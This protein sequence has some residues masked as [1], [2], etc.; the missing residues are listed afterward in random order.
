M[1]LGDF[2][3]G[4]ITKSYTREIL[5]NQMQEFSNCIQKNFYPVRGNH[6]GY[7][8]MSGMQHVIYDEDWYEATD[9]VD[10]RRGVSR[11][12]QKPYYFVDFKN[13]KVRLIVLS[14]F[15]YKGGD[16]NEPYCQVPGIDDLQIKWFEEKALKL[17][18]GWTVIICSHDVPFSTFS[19]NYYVGN[20]KKNG[21]RVI[22]I[23]KQREEEYGFK[24]AA[25]FI[26]HFHG[27]YITKIKGINFILVASETAYV[28]QLFNMPE[29]GYFPERTLNTESED[30]WDCVSLDKRNRKIRIFRFGAGIDREIDY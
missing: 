27:D 4:T 14:S 10:N 7:K 18:E 15:Y 9:F 29:G 26:G 13:E 30:L 25:W 23:L 24:T 8:D 3:T 1:H 5:I 20:S 6:D 16:G 11:D 2:L 28:P 21:N 12:A 22:E 17:G 19:E